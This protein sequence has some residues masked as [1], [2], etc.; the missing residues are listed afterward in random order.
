MTPPPKKKGGGGGGWGG[1][2]G[3]GG[4]IVCAL[5]AVGVGP[6]SDDGAVYDHHV[7][8][9][10]RVDRPIAW[11]KGQY[12]DQIA[13]VATGEGVVL[14]GWGGALYGKLFC[15]VGGSVGLGPKL[16]PNTPTLS[17]RRIFSLPKENISPT[18]NSNIFPTWASH[19][20]VTDRQAIDPHKV[21]HHR[22][23]VVVE[24]AVPRACG[25]HLICVVCVGSV[26]RW[27]AQAA[28]ERDPKSTGLILH[29][30]LAAAGVAAT[31]S[32]SRSSSST[33]Q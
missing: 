12:P 32:S 15:S 11:A 25:P 18:P 30:R 3:G 20:N 8:A 23:H 28:H 13:A 19:G 5:L 4:G 16:V 1:G 26:H 33:Q 10:G 14:K 24:R 27:C 6:G 22:A 17:T 9:E 31:R 2:G 21:Q 29:A 7:V